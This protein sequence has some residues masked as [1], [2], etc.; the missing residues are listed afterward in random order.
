EL[1]TVVALGEGITRTPL[2]PLFIKARD[3][4]SLEA[5]YLYHV[6][7]WF[8]PF[9]RFT[10][11]TALFSATDIRPG[12]VTYVITQRGGTKQTVVAS[13]LALTDPGRPLTMKETLGPFVRPIARDDVNVEI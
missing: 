13:R 2:V 4:L 10:L 11:D 6:V 9:A 8:G 3:A 5:I 12:P 7:P 1:R